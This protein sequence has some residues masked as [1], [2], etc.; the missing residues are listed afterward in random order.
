VDHE[1]RIGEA[2]QK[3]GDVSKNWLR[4]RDSYGTEVAEG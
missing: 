2:R 4:V 1:Y 3:G